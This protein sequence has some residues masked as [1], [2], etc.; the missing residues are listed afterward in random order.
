MIQGIMLAALIDRNEHIKGYRIAELP[1]DFN[2]EKTK[3]LKI[4]DVETYKIKYVIQAKQM[5]ISNL[6]IDENGDLT[7]IREKIS[8]YTRIN[9]IDNKIIGGETPIVILKQVI[10][11][12]ETIG[13]IVASFLGDTAIVRTSDAIEMAKRHGVANGKIVNRDG[14]EYICSIKGT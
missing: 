3:K 9:I 12:E 4:M 13:Y 5:N 2:A 6:K 7:T 1:S 14:E 10:S 8:R 11:Q